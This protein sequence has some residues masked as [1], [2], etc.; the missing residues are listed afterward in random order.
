MCLNLEELQNRI[1]ST[2]VLVRQGFVSVEEGIAQIER[3]NECID[4]W[5]RTH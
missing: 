3:L 2:K 4:L 1:Q 5:N